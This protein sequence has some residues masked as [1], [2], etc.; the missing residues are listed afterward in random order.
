MRRYPRHTTAM[1]LIAVVALVAI[2]GP[3]AQAQSAVSK[4]LNPA[5]GATAALSASVPRLVAGEMLTT[6]AELQE[7]LGRPGLPAAYPAAPRAMAPGRVG[8]TSST[9]SVILEGAAGGAIVNT[10]QYVA[11][12][13]FKL[14]KDYIWVAKGKHAGLWQNAGDGRCIADWSKGQITQLGN[15]ADKT[16]VYWTYSSEGKLWDNNTH[17]MLTASSTN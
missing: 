13:V 15:C 17:D 5:A 11:G 4:K 10:V 3:T 16:G 1:A 2:S 7:V 14:V 8:A 6:P 9:I 12:K